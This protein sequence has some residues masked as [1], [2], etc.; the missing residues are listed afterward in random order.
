M[1]D[2][3]YPMLPPGH[4]HVDAMSHQGYQQGLGIHMQIHTVTFRLCHAIFVFWLCGLV[5]RALGRPD[6]C[7][8]VFM[9]RNSAIRR[10]AEVGLQALLVERRGL[11]MWY[12][13]HPLAD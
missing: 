3:V 5:A 12:P 9:Y 1:L 4:W 11:H 7:T 8:S 6:H 13:P 10:F 2:T